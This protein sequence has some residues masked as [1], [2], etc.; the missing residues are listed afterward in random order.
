MSEQIRL[1]V[2]PDEKSGYSHAAQ[3]RKTHNCL[4]IDLRYLTYESLC[5]LYGKMRVDSH[6][7]RR[8]K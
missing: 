1:I 5:T 7:F 6:L 3:L 2:L 4:E 8:N